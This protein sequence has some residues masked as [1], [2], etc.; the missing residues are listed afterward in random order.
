MKS[1]ENNLNFNF[2]P[3]VNIGIYKTQLLNLDLKYWV[4]KLYSYQNVIS[5]EIKSNDSG[6]QSNSKIHLNPD[7]FPL[8]T[9]V[10]KAFQ[11]IFSNP[12]KQINAMWFNISPFGAFNH[13]HT[14]FSPYSH[15]E[16]TY[17]GVLY[18]KVPKNS[19]NIN[20]FSPIEL[21]ERRTIIPQEKDILIF[22]SI[23]P[24]S[25]NPNLSQE[26]RISIA[27]NFN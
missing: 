23:F 9:I 14:H 18:L 7:F 5:T 13:I 26:D 8:V 16:M 2:I 25:V 11:S 6:Y 22:P 20:F 15:P 10:N 4:E 27:F 3:W 24:H 21:N 17:S 1:Q 19:G 12:N